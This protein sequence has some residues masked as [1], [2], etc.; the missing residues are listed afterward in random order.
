MVLI[1]APFF[2]NVCYDWNDVY[3][4]NLLSVSSFSKKILI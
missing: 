3:Y 4:V 1:V 2:T